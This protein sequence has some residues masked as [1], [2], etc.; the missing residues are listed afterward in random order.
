[1]E[2][3]FYSF[4]SMKKKQ[5]KTKA[6]FIFPQIFPM[7]RKQNQKKNPR[8]ERQNKTKNKIK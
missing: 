2:K 3:N 4:V 7:E 6:A 5:N 1:M 8:L